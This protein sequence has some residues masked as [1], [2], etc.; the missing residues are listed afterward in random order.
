MGKIKNYDRAL[1][2]SINAGLREIIAPYKL[3][4]L[5]EEIALTYTPDAY[6]HAMAFLCLNDIP[7][8]FTFNPISPKLRARVV[9]VTWTEDDGTEKN[10]AWWE[11]TL[12]P[13][14]TWFVL[15]KIGRTKWIFMALPF[16]Q[17]RNIIIGAIRFLV[18]A[19]Q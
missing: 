3:I 17:P 5:G 9:M 10:L 1:Y 11:K 15:R 19:K 7:H 8:T 2:E 16:L 4:Q 13:T 12:L 6:E 18:C 14:T